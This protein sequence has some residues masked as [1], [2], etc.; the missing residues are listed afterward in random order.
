MSLW[1]YATLE[2]GGSAWALAQLCETHDAYRWLCGA[3]RSTTI[4]CRTSRWARA[5]ILG[6]LLTASVASLLA[7]GAVTLK[8]V[9]QDGMRARRGDIVPTQ[10]A[11]AA[12]QAQARQQVE[13]LGA[14]CMTIRK[15]PAGVDKRREQR[16]A[17]ALA[18]LPKLEGIKQAQ[19]K[20]ADTA[21]ASTTDAQARVM[22]MAGGGF[23]PAYNAQLASDTASQVIVGVDV[24][25]SGSDQGQ[26]V[27]MV[28]QI[29]QRYAHRP[30]ELLVDG[31]FARLDD[32]GTLA[33]GTTVYAPVPETQGPAGDRH[34]PCSGDIG[35]IAAWRQRMGTDAGKAVYKE[36]A[37]TAEC[38]N[39]LARNRGLQRFFNVCGLDRGGSMLRM[40][41]RAI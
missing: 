2:E 8:R 35:P 32:I 34:A 39:A 7:C 41:W 9:A 15:P 31:G 38:V 30:P 4:R 11:A 25:D 17:Q 16:I 3:C 13:A 29:E 27:P 12:F 37:A 19:G 28:R 33:L 5:R 14:K 40:R 36:R 1:L 26:M 6:E 22:K 18:Q 24:A 23:R 10:G 20:P 21:R